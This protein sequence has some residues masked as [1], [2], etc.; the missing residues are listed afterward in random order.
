MLASVPLSYNCSG[1]CSVSVKAL[2]PVAIRSS[3]VHRTVMR[4]CQFEQK[5][6]LIND[7]SMISRGPVQGN[8]F[9]LL[10]EITAIA[11]NYQDVIEMSILMFVLHKL[12]SVSLSLVVFSQ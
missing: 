2:R 7:L 6:H 1:L 12:L 3:A 10:Q 5:L 9:I 8:R 11:L 4:S